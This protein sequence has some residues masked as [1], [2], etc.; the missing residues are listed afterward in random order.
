MGFKSIITS[1]L[2]IALSFG[3]NAYAGELAY[4]DIPSSSPDGKAIH[5]LF[6]KAEKAAADEDIK[7]IISLYSKNYLNAGYATADM[8]NSW[9]KIFDMFNKIKMDHHIYQIQISSDGNRARMKCGGLLSG[10]ETHGGM[11]L[12]GSGAEPIVIDSWTAATHEFIKEDGQ[13]KIYGNQVN[14]DVGQE[15]HVLF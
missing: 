5:E 1:A 2:A 12:L 10:M 11:G 14:Y 9:T 3:V 7:G 6:V 15:R 4:T 8:R 13:W